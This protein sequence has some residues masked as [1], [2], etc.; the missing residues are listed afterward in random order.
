MPPG[1]YTNYTTDCKTKYTRSLVN[2]GTHLH[3]SFAWEEGRGKQR[4]ER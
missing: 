4:R 2:I 3:E 1:H